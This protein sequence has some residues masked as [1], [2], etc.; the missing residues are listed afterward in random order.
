MKTRNTVLAALGLSALLAA[1]SAWAQDAPGKG[2][3]RGDGRFLSGQMDGRCQFDG[4]QGK[5]HGHKNFGGKRGG[6]GTAIAL[7]ESK[8]SAAQAIASAEQDSSAR[9]YELDLGMYR[10][11]PAYEVELHDGKQELTV[12]IHAVSGEI[13]ARSSEVDH[14]APPSA[15]VS[16]SEAIEIAEKALDG[17]VVDAE[18]DTYGS[19]SAYKMRLH[20]AD[21]TRLHAFID[22]QDGKVLN[23]VERQ[24]RPFNRG[25][26]PLPQAA[27]APATPQT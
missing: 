7:A 8:I 16:L 4:R 9:A 24:P 10:D 25:N 23:S 27:P 26:R 17:T 6:R 19:A 21:G 12:R 15:D 11:Q 1:T 18:L 2:N 14:D 20:K 5:A 13:I 3:G 22:A